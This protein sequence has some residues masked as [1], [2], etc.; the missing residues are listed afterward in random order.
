MN[1]WN[2]TTSSNCSL[3]EDIEFL[4]SSDCQLQVSGGNS[5]HLEVF[6]GISGKFQNFGSQVLKD[7][8]TVDSRGSSDSVLDGDSSFK[9]SVNSSDWEL[10]KAIK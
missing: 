1:V 9:E 2:D 6:G 5:S 4:V 8:S 3:D 7:S 10:K